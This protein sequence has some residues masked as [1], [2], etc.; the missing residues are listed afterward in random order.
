M[1]MWNLK[2]VGR[3]IS[4]RRTETRYK[5]ELK[6]MSLLDK[7]KSNTARISY[8]KS[9]CYTRGKWLCLPGR[10]HEGYSINKSFSDKRL[11]YEKSAE[12]IVVAE[13]S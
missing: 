10:S 5:V 13:Q 6:W 7:V 3:K 2:E 4:N 12:A 11:N 1:V 9:S 8:S